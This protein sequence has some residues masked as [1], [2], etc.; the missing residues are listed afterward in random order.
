MECLGGGRWKEGG[1]GKTRAPVTDT[2]IYSVYIYIYVL[3]F[4]CMC[5]SMFWAGHSLNLE[6]CARYTKLRILG[7]L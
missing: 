5:L 1:W 4:G 7:V 3:V 6:F 2:Y